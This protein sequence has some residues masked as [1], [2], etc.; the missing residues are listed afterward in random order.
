MTLVLLSPESPEPDHRSRAP[1]P[2]RLEWLRLKAAADREARA[3][4][5]AQVAKRK[6]MASCTPNWRNDKETRQALGDLRRNQRRWDD[7]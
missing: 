4:R 1:S 7:A 5:L 2:E 6:P 3:K